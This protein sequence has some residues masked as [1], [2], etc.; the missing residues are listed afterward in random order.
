MS[1]Y[2]TLAFNQ[3]GV[4]VANLGSSLALS[5]VPLAQS[6]FVRYIVS[7]GLSNKK[8]ISLLSAKDYQLLR[9]KKPESHP[10]LVRAAILQQEQAKFSLPL[11]QLVVD[12]FEAARLSDDRFLF[13]V[14]VAKRA[15]K[16]HYQAIVTASL[17]PV[18]ITV[19]ELIYA[20]Y[21]KIKYADHSTVIWLNYFS[22]SIQ[23]I[24]VYQ[25]ELIATLK[26][27]A[28]S[29]AGMSPASIAALNLFYVTEVQAFSASPLWLL[30]GVF[31]LDLAMLDQLSG[32]KKWMRD[33]VGKDFYHAL[34]ENNQSSL[35][36]AYYG[37]M[38]NE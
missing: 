2:C 9:I 23:V 12:Y 34:E 17:Q 8:V 35:S 38:I 30:N 20:H 28:T 5:S 11:D 24:A 22:D 26:L 33:E 3:A 21:A 31:S 10:H 7:Q 14:A 1:K 19:H 25:G 4:T 29:E 6:E 27:P 36:H 15:L 13:V 16:E 37:L 18:K 32:T